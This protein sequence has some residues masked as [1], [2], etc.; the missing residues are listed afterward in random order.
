MLLGIESSLRSN[1]ARLAEIASQVDIAGSGAVPSGARDVLNQVSTAYSN[2]AERASEL[3]ARL[4][5]AANELDALNSRAAWLE[6]EIAT[7]NA[8][9]S[10]FGTNE[11]K[12]SRADDEARDVRRD[13][14]ERFKES[15][16]G[17]VQLTRLEEAHSFWYYLPSE[18]PGAV[19]KTAKDTATG[20][21]DGFVA[22]PK[23]AVGLY[24]RSAIN[25]LVDREE[26]DRKWSE[27][28]RSVD[29][30]ASAYS[31]LGPKQFFLQVGKNV[32][33]NPAKLGGNILGG[34]AFGEVVS[35]GTTLLTSSRVAGTSAGSVADDILSSGARLD[36]IASTAGA[37]HDASAA[38]LGLQSARA[39]E[40]WS[41][42][43]AGE[44]QSQLP[45]GSQGRVTMGTGVLEDASGVQI[46]V[47]STSEANGYLRPGVTL[48]PGEITVR[49]VGHA[50]ADIVN[51]AANNG[52][53]VLTV[54]AGRPICSA[55]ANSI[56]ESGASAATVLKGP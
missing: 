11:W 5:S 18:F 46:R 23:L 31:Q 24:E 25:Y 33:S 29:A 22:L 30:V 16:K 40:T 49:G 51:F 41:A 48:Q 37:V 19:V 13:L 38:R 47:V 44:L 8:L 14:A 52:Y 54:G 6:E 17:D 28:E 2:A 32:V 10:F 9:E 42:A 4:I 50:E 27:T 35:V 3:S 36:D 39:N 12:L 1:A 7:D 26:F 21:K 43:R 15:A 56:L 45:I 53:S 34:L 55:C 20:F